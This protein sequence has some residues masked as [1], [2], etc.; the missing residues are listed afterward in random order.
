MDP[1]YLDCAEH[2]SAPCVI[3]DIELSKTYVIS[4]FWTARNLIFRKLLISSFE[5][6]VFGIQGDNQSV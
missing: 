4:N 1:I 5:Y 3:D 2:I 6:V